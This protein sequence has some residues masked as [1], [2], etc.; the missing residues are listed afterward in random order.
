MTG[1]GG[2]EVVVGGGGPADVTLVVEEL[3]GADPRAA[4]RGALEAD[5]IAAASARTITAPKGAH[6]LHRPRATSAPYALAGVGKLTP[7]ASCR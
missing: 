1:R 4:P 5:Q 2:T 7:I 3:V 6:E